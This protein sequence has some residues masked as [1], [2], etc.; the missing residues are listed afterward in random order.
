MFAVVDEQRPEASS[1]GQ[2]RTEQ[3]RDRGAGSGKGEDETLP[4]IVHGRGMIRRMTWTW[5]RT[6]PTVNPPECSNLGCVRP[7]PR[8]TEA[9]RVSSD[10]MQFEEYR[11]AAPRPRYVYSGE[12]DES[13]GHAGGS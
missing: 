1:S 8:D 2:Q 3:G 4:D 11:K 10:R 12:G 13:C 6:F 5:T 7:S 9:V